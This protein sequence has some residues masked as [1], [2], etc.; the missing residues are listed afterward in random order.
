MGGKKVSDKIGVIENLID[1]ADSIIIGGGMTYTFLKAQGYEVGKSIYE[2]DKLDLAL[3][4]LE[5]AKNKGVKMLF[6]LD[7]VCGA[8]FSNDTEAV[9]VK[10]TEIPEHLEGLDIGPESIKAFSEE[11]RKAKTVMWNGPVGV[12]EFDKFAV[13]T[14]EIA[15]VLSE[16]DATTII[17]GGDSAAAIEKLG[18]AD[19]MTHISTGGGASLEY[20]E[21]KVLPGIAC[22]NDK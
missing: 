2:V 11:L 8:E 18:Y 15:K 1:K 14:N 7:T 13:G 17:G 21:G 3:D 4:L 10:S 22:L 19:K 16:I 5:K 9:L 6:P 20:I 12:F